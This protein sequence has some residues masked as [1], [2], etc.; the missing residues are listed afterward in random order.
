MLIV[1]ILALT[2]GLIRRPIHVGASAQA[3]AEVKCL[4]FAPGGGGLYTTKGIFQ[5]SRFSSFSIIV[6]VIIIIRHKD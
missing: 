5:S 6:I 2:S 4:R 1:K 3:E